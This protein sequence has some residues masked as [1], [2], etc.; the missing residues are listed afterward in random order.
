MHRKK[1]S[2]YYSYGVIAW[3]IQ[4][5]SRKKINRIFKARIVK[6]ARY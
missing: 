3:K 6:N 1:S 4:E 2:L 5:K